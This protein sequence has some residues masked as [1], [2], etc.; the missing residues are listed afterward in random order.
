MWNLIVQ[1][2]IGLANNLNSTD[3]ESLVGNQR[4]N[5]TI[6]NSSITNADISNQ[7]KQYSEKLCK[8]KRKTLEQYTPL[9]LE[10]EST[11]CYKGDGN[12]LE[13]DL[14]QTN[15]YQNKTIIMQNGYIVLVGN[16]DDSSPPLDIYIDAGNLYLPSDLQA[17][18]FTLFD[19]QGFP[20]TSNGASAGRF[21]KGNIIIN[22]LLIGGI[23]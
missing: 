18:T 19:Q 23:P 11:L 13:I 2:T 12:T 7:A 1:G 16:M 14:T 8:G 15:I 3:K 9:Q 6:F 22:G 17:N 4:G 20:V 21:L 10:K 5:S